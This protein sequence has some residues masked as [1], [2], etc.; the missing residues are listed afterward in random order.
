LF[1]KSSLH[2]L[3]VVEEVVLIVVEDFDR[4]GRF[5]GSTGDF[6]QGCRFDSGI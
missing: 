6:G 3:M 1:N 2:F 4:E 5:D